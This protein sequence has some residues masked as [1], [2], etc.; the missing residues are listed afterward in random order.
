MNEQ[1]RRAVETMVLSG[2]GKEALY[3]IF[4]TFSHEA[5]DDVYESVKAV[6]EA[7]KAVIEVKCNCS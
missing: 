4:P 7:D 6:T 5:I 1:D 3:A 2:M